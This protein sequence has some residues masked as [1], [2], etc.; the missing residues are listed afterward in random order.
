MGR[1]HSRYVT[2]PLMRP[3]DWIW[4][5]GRKGED[6]QL[7]YLLPRPDCSVGSYGVP[8]G[9]GGLYKSNWWEEVSLERKEDLCDTLE[10]DSG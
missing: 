10:V 4:K 8:A 3:G 6:G 2:E 1:G 9:F 7:A 5:N